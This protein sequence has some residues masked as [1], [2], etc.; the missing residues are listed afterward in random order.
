MEGAGW[1][2]RGFGQSLICCSSHSVTL[3]HFCSLVLFLRG[4]LHVDFFLQIL[5]RLFA[6]LV[7][8]RLPEPRDPVPN[9][10]IY[11]TIPDMPHTPP[12]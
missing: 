3:A 12:N 11:T 8:N 9:A 10:A 2:D 5:A 6:R 7:L 4:W 1:V